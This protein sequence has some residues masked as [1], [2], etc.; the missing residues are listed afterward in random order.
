MNPTGCSP[1]RSCGKSL[2]EPCAARIDADQLGV[3]CHLVTHPV[4]ER[5]ERLLGVREAFGGASVALVGFALVK[6]GLQDELC[7]DLIA[8]AFLRA[9][10]DAG[11][12]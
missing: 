9:R 12:R 2:G 11:V 8:D 7:G 3:R 5:G 1:G 4:G 6:I 10:L